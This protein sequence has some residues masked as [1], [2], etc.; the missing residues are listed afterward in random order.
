MFLK[1]LLS[2]LVLLFSFF[3]HSMNM[4]DEGRSSARLYLNS[5]HMEESTSIRSQR[6][7]MG[8]QFKS[9]L[10]Y[11]RG[12]LRKRMGYALGLH[13]KPDLTKK[14]GEVN[15]LQDFYSV[16]ALLD[17]NFVF[18]FRF[19]LQA[20]PGALF[21][22]TRSHVLNTSESRTEMS[23]LANA[24]LSIDYAISKDWEIGWQL[25]AQYRWAHEKWDWFQGFGLIYNF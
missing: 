22:V 13:A 8:L 6:Y 23:G 19:S 9:P 1:T 17:L 3:A 7:G 20:G 15:I 10:P 18:L 5:A 2:A 14:A 24:G 16:D 12:T 11:S 25:R 21:S 4:E